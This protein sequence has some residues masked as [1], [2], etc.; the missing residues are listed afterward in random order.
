MIFHDSSATLIRRSRLGALGRPGQLRAH[1]GGR[2]GHQDPDRGRVADGVQIEHQQP[3]VEVEARG[4]GAV[5]DPL[6]RPLAEVLER[7][8]CAA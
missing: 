1:P 2:A 5:E 6:Q 4:R 3:R 8:R 7:Q